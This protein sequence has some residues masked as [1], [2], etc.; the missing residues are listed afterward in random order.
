MQQSRKSLRYSQAG[1]V[2]IMTTMVLMI[3]ISLIVLGFAQL[4][5]RNQRE[6]L[7]RQLSSQAFYAAESGVNDVRELIQGAVAGGTVNI[8]EKDG[9]TDTG[10]GGFYASLNPDI[11]TA[12]NVRYTCLL[13]DPSP[14]VLRYSDVGTTS[15]VVPMISASGTNFSE[16]TIDWQSKISGTNPLTGCPTST[17]NAFTPT[18][19]W[20]CGYGVLR[21]DLVPVTGALTADSLRTSTMTTFA[22]PFSSGGVSTAP[23]QAD[24]TNNNRRGVTCT[25]S[26]C[27]LT[28]TGLNRSA[29]YLRVSSLYR[30]AAMQISGASA[31]GANLEISGAQVVIDATGKAQDVLRRVQVHVPLRAS[32]QNQLSDYAIQSTDAICKRF[33]VMDGFFDP[34][35]TGVTSTNRLCQP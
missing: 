5:R 31:G 26:S 6:T 34:S 32:S 4:S 20:S 23:F 18:S 9:C 14:E 29:Y 16:V 3:V 21:F 7:D 19:S 22:V 15:L 1:M 35:V 30:G 24:T 2:S 10:T 13:V 27:S 8:P 33:S 11:D 17:T 28:I 25:S 12:T